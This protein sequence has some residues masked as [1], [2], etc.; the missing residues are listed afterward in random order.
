VSSARAE[1]TVA[2]LGAALAGALAL[3]AGGQSWALISHDRP[4][5]LPDRKSVV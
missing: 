5:P 4:A 2:V 3:I 1:L